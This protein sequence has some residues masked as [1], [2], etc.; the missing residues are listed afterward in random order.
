MRKFFGQ[1]WVI[2][3]T[4]RNR[5]TTQTTSINTTDVSRDQANIFFAH[6]TTVHAQHAHG[7]GFGTATNTMHVKRDS[8]RHLPA[9]APN[10]QPNLTCQASK[11]LRMHSYAEAGA[12]HQLLGVKFSHPTMTSCNNKWE[13]NQ[14]AKATYHN[15]VFNHKILRMHALRNLRQ[16]P[17]ELVLCLCVPSW[18]GCWPSSLGLQGSRGSGQ[19]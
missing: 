7:I 15:Q 8:R 3:C 9:R 13:L 18:P 4:A 17:V 1:Q 2:T 10:P 19:V 11:V 5:F 16:V 12:N 6:D 14:H